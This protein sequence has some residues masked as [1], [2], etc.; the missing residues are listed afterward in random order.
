ML[1][2]R[3][4]V[5]VLAVFHPFLKYNLAYSNICLWDRLIRQDRNRVLS[6]HHRWATISYFSQSC[7]FFLFMLLKSKRCVFVILPPFWCVRAPLQAPRS[8]G[9]VDLQ[10]CGTRPTGVNVPTWRFTSAAPHQGDGEMERRVAADLFF[11]F[12]NHRWL[13]WQ[14]GVERLA[15]RGKNKLEKKNLFVFVIQNTKHTAGW[16]PRERRGK[17]QW[18]WKF[19][20]VKDLWVKQVLTKNEWMTRTQKLMPH[21]KCGSEKNKTTPGFVFGPGP[22][23]CSKHERAASSLKK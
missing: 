13:A 5:R 6:T 7:R 8:C 11:F 23:H 14:L 21:C 1:K 12:I 18:R 2:P 9:E 17:S 4:F 3:R 22:L 19:R 20:Q 15:R 10:L 16:S